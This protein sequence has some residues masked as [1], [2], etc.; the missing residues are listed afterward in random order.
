MSRDQKTILCAT[1]HSHCYL[2]QIN[3]FIILLTSSPVELCVQI[4]KMLRVAKTV[5]LDVNN[6]YA[7]CAARG[8]EL[9]LES[10]GPITKGNV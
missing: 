3:C 9:V 6:I 1:I 7:L 10:T 8:V 5:S 4:K 2:F